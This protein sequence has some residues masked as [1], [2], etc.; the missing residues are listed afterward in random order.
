[1]SLKLETKSI[2]AELARI[3]FRTQAFIDGRFAPSAGGKTYA[4]VNPAN[5]RT[6]AEVA[7]CEPAEVNRAVA[8]ARRAFDDSVW[9][10]LNPADR[11]K[12]LLRFAALIEAHAGEIA[13]LDAL[14]AGKPIVDCVNID[15]PDTVHWS[16]VWPGTRS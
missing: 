7:A 9:S 3:Q 1:M 5:G 4:A 12:T 14:S 8:A 6:L 13:L 2:Q 10:R 11:K 16:I 15:L